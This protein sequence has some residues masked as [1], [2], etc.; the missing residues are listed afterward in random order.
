MPLLVPRTAQIYRHLMDSWKD[1]RSEQVLSIDH[2]LPGPSPTR[3][4]KL[5]HF[6]ARRHAKKTERVFCF[7]SRLLVITL[8]DPLAWSAPTFRSIVS[9]GFVKSVRHLLL[10]ALI[11][12]SAHLDHHHH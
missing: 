8:G 5:S 4:P 3:V 2:D 7:G 10:L 12:R 6:K 9:T 1:L 11:S